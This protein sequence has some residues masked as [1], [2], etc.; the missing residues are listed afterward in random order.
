[1]HLKVIGAVAAYTIPVG[2]ALR[3]AAGMPA[4]AQLGAATGNLLDPAVIGK[5]GLPLPNQDIKFQT[6]GTPHIDVVVPQATMMQFMGST[7]YTSAPHIGSSRYAEKG[8]LLELTATNT[9]GAHHPFHLHGF[10]FQPVSLAPRAGAPA[11]VT[12]TVGPPWPYNEFRDTIDLF[13]DHTLTFRVRLDDRELADGL[14]PSGFGALGRWLFHCHIFFH[15][16]QGMIS[17]LVVTTADGKEKPN[18]NVGG[19][20][21]FKPVGGTATRQGTFFHRDGL[22]MTLAATKGIVA[23]VGPGP[24]GAWNW[25]YNSANWGPGE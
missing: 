3:A 24:G 12:G 1:M 22:N 13:P 16:M 20:W 17:E 4:V 19:S 15:H 25:H 10:S 18:V 7:P 11:G 9:S 23:P 5:T 2:T 6:G 14:A 8:K 21:E